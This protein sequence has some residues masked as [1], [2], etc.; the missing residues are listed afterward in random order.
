MDED[1]RAVRNSVTKWAVIGAVV[2]IPVPF[3]GP[4]VGAAV[5]AGIGYVR[6]KKRT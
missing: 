5:G 2:A 1:G 6:A 3:V 4:L